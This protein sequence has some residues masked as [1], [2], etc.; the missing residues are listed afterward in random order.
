[1][2]KFESR[3][4]FFFSSCRSLGVFGANFWVQAVPRGGVREEEITQHLIWSL[5]VP[6]A[7]TEKYLPP[8]IIIQLVIN[9]YSI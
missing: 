6:S 2:I 9:S 1:M 5:A 7:K 3:Y 4:M 8:Q